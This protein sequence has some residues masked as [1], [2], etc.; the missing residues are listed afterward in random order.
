MS[1]EM[2]LPILRPRWMRIYRACLEAGADGISSEDL[3]VRMYA[4]DEWPTPGGNTVMRVCIHEI[5]QII[6]ERSERIINQFRG[7]YRLVHVEDQDAEK[8]VHGEADH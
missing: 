6:A 5:N 4:D 2:A 3:L 1:G 8:E 7:R